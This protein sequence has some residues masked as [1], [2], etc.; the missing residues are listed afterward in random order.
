VRAAEVRRRQ[1]AAQAEID[2]RRAK[3]KTK[4]PPDQPLC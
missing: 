2:R 3:I 4:C 1:A